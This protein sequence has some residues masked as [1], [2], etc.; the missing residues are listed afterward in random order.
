MPARTLAPRTPWGTGEATHARF[1]EA[2]GQ[3]VWPRRPSALADALDVFSTG[4]AA[5]VRL[6]GPVGAHGKSSRSS[7]AGNSWPGQSRV[8]A[9]EG[10]IGSGQRRAGRGRATEHV[11]SGARSLWSAPGQPA[12]GSSTTNY[13]PYCALADRRRALG[14][15]SSAAAA[16]D[17]AARSSGRGFPGGARGILSAAQATVLLAQVRHRRTPPARP[18]VVS[19]HRCGISVSRSGGFQMSAIRG[20]AS[21]A[22]GGRPDSCLSPESPEPRFRQR[23]ALRRMSRHGAAP[24]DRDERRC[25]LQIREPGRGRSRRRGRARA[26]CASPPPSSGRDGRRCRAAL[27]LQPSPNQRVM[28]GR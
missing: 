4:A 8:W 27:P 14:E 17:A 9:I 19:A 20:C 25:Q 2:V 6:L 5:L 11:R 15:T 16:D 1:D 12:S 13:S 23:Q 26:G 21:P 10:C 22:D 7:P 3:A 24:G 18:A 28:S